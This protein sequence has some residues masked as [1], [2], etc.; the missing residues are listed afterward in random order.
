[1]ICI[2]HATGAG[3][4]ELGQAVA[5]A[6][7]YRFVDEEVIARAAESR[8]VTVAELANVERRRSFLSRM[9]DE[10][11]RSQ[12]GMYGVVGVPVDLTS[13]SPDTLRGLIRQSI[14][15]MAAE[16]SVVIASHAASYALGSRD[17]VL[18]VLVTASPRTRVRRLAE[19]EGLDDA[20]ATKAIAAHDAGRRDYLKRFYGVGSEQPTDY[21]VVLNTDTVDSVEFCDI[22]ARAAAL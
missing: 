10:F 21:D 4:P 17:D 15:E 8:D 14:E 18:R 6:M 20:A 16:G 3:G 11:G 7:D 13:L 1:M 12:V 19:T 2:S 22:I 9:V 5:D